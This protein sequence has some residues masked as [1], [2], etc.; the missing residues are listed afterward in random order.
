MLQYVAR[1]LL[2]LSPLDPTV[3]AWLEPREPPVR[4]VILPELVRAAS[5]APPFA[6]VLDDTQTLQNPQCWRLVEALLE[7]LPPGC[8]LVICGRSVPALPVSRLQSQ[9]RVSVYSFHDLAFDRHEVARL[10]QS[11]G[12]AYGEDSVD[13]LLSATEGWAAAVYL[14]ILAWRSATCQFGPSLLEIAARSP[15]TSPPKCWPGSHPTWCG[16]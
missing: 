8:S 12:V 16:S 4:N 9:D 14:A 15:T 2:T 11:H 10:L 6:L 1:A 5:L 7:A 13:G 3:L